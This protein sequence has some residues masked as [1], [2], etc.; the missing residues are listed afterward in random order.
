MM[1]MANRH[2]DEEARITGDALWRGAAQQHGDAANAPRARA[3]GSRRDSMR[4]PRGTGARGRGPAPR[5]LPRGAHR[6]PR[7]AGC[8][9]HDHGLVGGCHRR[10]SPLPRLGARFCRRMCHRDDRRRSAANHSIKLLEPRLPFC[11]GPRRRARAARHRVVAARVARAR[12]AR[13]G[14]ARAAVVVDR[15]AARPRAEAAARG[16]P[17]GVRD[18]RVRRRGSRGP[19]RTPRRPCARGSTRRGRASG[20]SRTPTC[21]SRSA[22][23]SRRRSAATGL[24]FVA[25]PRRELLADDG[26]RARARVFQDAPPPPPGPLGARGATAG[27]R[28]ARRGAHVG[29]RAVRDRS[30]PPMDAALMVGDCVRLRKDAHARRWWRIVAIDLPGAAIVAALELDDDA[31]LA[32]SSSAS[33][34]PGRAPS[35][36]RR[37][38][39][40]HLGAALVGGARAARTRWRR[41]TSRTRRDCSR[42]RTRAATAC[43]VPAAGFGGVLFRLPSPDAGWALRRAARVRRA[44]AR[45]RA[46]AARARAVELAG[47]GAS[48][49]CSRSARGRARP[50][51]ARARRGS[52]A[53][54][55]ASDDA[56]GWEDVGRALA[57][58]GPLALLRDFASWSGEA[59]AARAGRDAASCARLWRTC[60]APPSADTCARAPRA[61]PRATRRSAAR[62]DR[63]DARDVRA[64]CSGSPPTPCSRCRATARSSSSSSTRRR[65]RADRGGPRCACAR[66][67]ALATRTRATPCSTTSSSACD[68]A[69]RTCRPRRASRRARAATRARYGADDE[70]AR[71]AV[72]PARSSR[73][74][75][76][77]LAAPAPS[78]RGEAIAHVEAPV[79]AG[80][81]VRPRGRARVARGASA[82]PARARANT[83]R[84][85]PPTPR[86]ARCARPP[87]GAR[88]ARRARAR[89]RARPRRALALTSC[90]ARRSARGERRQARGRR[91]AA[92]RSSSC[93]RRR[94]VGGAR[95]LRQGGGR[96]ATTRR[97]ASRTARSTMARRARRGRPPSRSPTAARHGGGAPPLRAAELTARG[98]A[99]ATRATPVVG[100]AQAQGARAALA[101][102]R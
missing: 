84:P 31:C 101:H 78:C 23:R 12:A 25:A 73:S 93:A 96:A 85:P 95:G 94:G 88:R 52:T 79:R 50:R 14:R 33:P 71:V 34:R 6:A 62:D 72:A 2:G 67:T 4:S 64:A 70:Q 57:A 65:R 35:A 102:D 47:R 28:P 74:C 36:P 29:R 26:A 16:R 24:V 80:D 77:R 43:A 68:I 49:S 60:R 11:H 53:R 48:T 89:T 92:T 51:G 22:T 45:A 17:R 38:G 10:R 13:A 44:D 56:G 90:G 61:R 76:T 9:V 21:R 100:V 20:R 58:C 18:R 98:L 1:I 32:R 86:P 97:A 69:T 27:A 66:T 15:P 83:A 41:A 5:L 8:T 99:N 59:T 81:Y 87:R 30:A 3:R 39:A 40:E 91:A 75:R 42:A 46:P 55:R 37:I 82:R 63:H 7:A 54:P 19:R